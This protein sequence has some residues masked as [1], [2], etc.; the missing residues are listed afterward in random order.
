MRTLEDWTP[1]RDKLC[2]YYP[3]RRNPSAAAKAFIDLA[4]AS[5]AGQDGLA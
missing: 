1:P 3:N 2:L 5:Q 4:R